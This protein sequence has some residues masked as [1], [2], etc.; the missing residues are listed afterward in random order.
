M[1]YAAAVPMGGY[2]YPTDQL[3]RMPGESW[4]GQETR[5]CWVVLLRWGAP[6]CCCQLQAAPLLH[7]ALCQPA[8]VHVWCNR[9][10]SN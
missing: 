5:A 4:Q 8:E 9:L 1:G 3:S 6:C 2:M 10:R 7:P